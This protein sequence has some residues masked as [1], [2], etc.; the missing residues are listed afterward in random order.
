MEDNWCHFLHRRLGT[1]PPLLVTVVVKRHGRA[2]HLAR[3]QRMTLVCAELFFVPK[4]PCAGQP[5]L[6]Q[7]YVL[8]WSMKER[9]FFQW[10]RE[11]RQLWHRMGGGSH[12]SCTSLAF[13]SFPS[14]RNNSHPDFYEVIITVPNSRTVETRIC[15]WAPP[16]IN[17][18][19]PSF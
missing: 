16:V 19:A 1:H 14:P 12:F 11:R 4:S 18:M 7:F 17:L 9:L 8:S 3:E 2:C 10:G 6:F 13:T 15:I 5:V